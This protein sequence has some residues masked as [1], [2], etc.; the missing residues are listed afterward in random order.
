MSCKV[1]VA[2]VCHEFVDESSL[3]GSWSSRSFLSCSR[4][5]WG[6]FREPAGG[7]PRDLRGALR[8]SSM[9]NFARR[10]QWCRLLHRWRP[11]QWRFRPLE[12]EE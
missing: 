10:W 3:A 9:R 4:K 12:A 8:K 11:E 7:Q 5:R 1:T 2:T 6:S